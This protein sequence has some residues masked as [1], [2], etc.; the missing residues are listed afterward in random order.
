MGTTILGINSAYHESSV[1]LLRDGEVLSAVEEERF[2]R[3]K[4]GRYQPPSLWSV[5]EVLRRVGGLGEVTVGTRDEGLG[6]RRGPRG[7]G[8][9]TPALLAAL[10]TYN[11]SRDVTVFDPLACACQDARGTG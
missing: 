4:H 1:C 3:V 9:C 6:P 11:A 8:R 5:I 10:A 2:N 7:C